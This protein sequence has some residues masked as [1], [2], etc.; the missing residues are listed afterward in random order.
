VGIQL[1]IS[2][3]NE[4]IER[5]KRLSMVIQTLPQPPPNTCHLKDI[6]VAS[7]ASIDMYLAT[8]GDSRSLLSVGVVEEDG[9]E[10]KG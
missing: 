7:V 1:K 5:G 8:L 10:E 9:D 3:W 6:P 4:L 2:P